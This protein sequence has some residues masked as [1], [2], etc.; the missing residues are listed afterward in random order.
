MPD[1]SGCFYGAK[2]RLATQADAVTVARLTTDSKSAAKIALRISVTMAGSPGRIFI[3]PITEWAILSSNSKSEVVGE[4]TYFSAVATLSG[5]A[6][7]K[8]R[9]GGS[10]VALEARAERWLQGGPRPPF[11]SIPD[12]WSLAFDATVFMSR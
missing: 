2:N 4:N 5:E 1:V 8:Q 9:G 12:S 7:G 3:P 10:F 11:R 6:L